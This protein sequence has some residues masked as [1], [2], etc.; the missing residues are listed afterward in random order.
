MSERW[1]ME[2]IKWVRSPPWNLTEGVMKDDVPTDV[3]KV[4]PMTEEEGRRID[5]RLPNVKENG[6]RVFHY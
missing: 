3:P 4:I 5:E 1:I 2:E 6:I